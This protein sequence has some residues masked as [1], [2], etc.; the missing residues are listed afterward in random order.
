S[1]EDFT[2]SEAEEKIESLGSRAT[3]RVSSSTDY[4]VVGENPGSKLDMAKKENVE[5]IK[6]KQFKNL[7]K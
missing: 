5:I 3:S 6:E 1:L 2:R 7:L 4:L